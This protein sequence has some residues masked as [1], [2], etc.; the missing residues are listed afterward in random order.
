MYVP[1]PSTTTIS[2]VLLQHFFL[3]TLMKWLQIILAGPGDKTP[4]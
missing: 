4:W 1:S 2:L 3:L